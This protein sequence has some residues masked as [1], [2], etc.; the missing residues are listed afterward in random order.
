MLV[1]IHETDCQHQPLKDT[2]SLQ[3]PGPLAWALAHSWC[4]INVCWDGI[5]EKPSDQT[6]IWAYSPAVALCFLEKNFRAE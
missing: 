2:C 3:P 1:L 6:G 5:K 4:L